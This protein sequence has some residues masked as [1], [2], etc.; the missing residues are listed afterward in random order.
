MFCLLPSI[1]TS[2]GLGFKSLEM[3]L[4]WGQAASNR[5]LKGALCEVQMHSLG[6]FE[7]TWCSEANGQLDLGV[8]LTAY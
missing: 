8:L 5:M 1:C 4:L 7:H 2:V 3:T 6:I